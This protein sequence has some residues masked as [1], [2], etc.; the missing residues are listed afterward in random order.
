MGRAKS[1]FLWLTMLLAV[2][3]VEYNI[4]NPNESVPGVPNPAPVPNATRLDRIT[5]VAKPK[6][7]VLWVIDNSCS[8][9][10]EQT[11]LTNNFD[12]FINYFIGSGLDWHVGV[13]S[14][15]MSRNDHKGQL[16]MAGGLTYLDESSPS[17]VALFREMAAMGTSGSGSEQG[18]DSSYSALEEHRNGF[19][20]GFYRDDAILNIIV[21]S[22]EEDQSNDIGLSEYISWL[23]NLK[24]DEEDVTFSSIVCLQVGTLN[25]VTCNTGIFS[26]MTVGSRYVTVTQALNGVLWD[27]RETDWAEVLEELGELAVGLK[28]E[29][30]LSDIPIPETLNVWVEIPDIAGEG[31]LTYS[32][33][34]HIDYVYSNTRNSI[35]F[36]TYLPPQYSQVHIEYSLLSSDYGESIEDSGK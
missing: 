23:R 24:R 29:F 5:Q 3:C 4:E 34:Q 2:S 36:I 18:L 27:I 15:D 16:Q 14:M 1:C 22:D 6:T 19:N 35:T 31:M 13:V 32:F 26:A 20:Q 25:N 8:M 7:D 28:R 10:E 33:K 12:A 11:A 21:I 30:F 9:D 17:P